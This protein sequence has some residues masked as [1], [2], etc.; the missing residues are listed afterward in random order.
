MGIILEIIIRNAVMHYWYI[1]A[2]VVAV[3]A[4]LWVIGK[5]EMIREAREAKAS[6]GLTEGGDQS[7]SP[8]KGSAA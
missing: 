4:V 6:A 1:T 7:V 8:V 5:R 2:P 3:L